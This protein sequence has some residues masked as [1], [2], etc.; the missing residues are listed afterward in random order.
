PIA[1]A[2]ALR[3]AIP[4]ARLQIIPGAAHLAPVERP[5]SVAEAMRRFLKPD[6]ADPDAVGLAV[7]KQVLGEAHVARAT[8]AITDLARD[9][10]AFLTR[11]AWGSVWPRPGLDR[12]TRSLLTLAML[13]PP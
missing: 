1:A 4:G 12:R 7:R 2:E 6:G 8:E 9:F 13:A 11:P 5:S 3:D 10:Q